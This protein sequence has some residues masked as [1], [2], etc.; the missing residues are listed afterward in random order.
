MVKNNFQA[1]DDD[2]LTVFDRVG[3]WQ[4]TVGI[5]CGILKMRFS[6]TIG[7]VRTLSGADKDQLEFRSGGFA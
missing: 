5:E 3:D 6:R 2:F 4:V 7:R 1:I